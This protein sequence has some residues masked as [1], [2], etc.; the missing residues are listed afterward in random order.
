LNFP[1]LHF[2]RH[3]IINQHQWIYELLS[4]SSAWQK[5]DVLNRG[6]MTW[7]HLRTAPNRVCQIK[8]TEHIYKVNTGASYDHT[9]LSS[10]LHL[11]IFSHDSRLGD[12]IS[13]LKGH[14]QLLSVLEM[15]RRT[16]RKAFWLL[17]GPVRVVRRRPCEANP[18]QN[19]TQS[20]WPHFEISCDTTSIPML[21]RI[22][23]YW[24]G[25]FTC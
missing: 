11:L 15:I 21:H 13:A 7:I 9:K 5:A 3:N 23:R 20:K 4:F 10:C 6:V 19:Q 24:K 12:I 25:T 1:H 17:T 8:Q 16:Q 2:W 14:L 18:N 22:V